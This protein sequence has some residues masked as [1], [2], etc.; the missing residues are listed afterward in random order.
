MFHVDCMQ[1]FI[2]VVCWIKPVRMI[3][4]TDNSYPMVSCSAACNQ[5]NLQAAFCTELFSVKNKEMQESDTLLTGM[6][7][8][9]NGNGSH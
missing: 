7:R 2:F 9:R 8:N 5:T 3:P 1:Q 6:Y 4:Q